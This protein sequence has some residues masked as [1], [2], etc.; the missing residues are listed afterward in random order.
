[1]LKLF[2]ILASGLAGG[3]LVGALTAAPPPEDAPA[4][5]ARQA[6]YFD[7]SLP[8]AERLQALERTVAAERDARQVLEEQILLLLEE[9]DRIGANRPATLPGDVPEGIGERERVAAQ[10]EAR[11]AS[12]IIQRAGDTRDEQLGS[13]MAAGF[14]PSQAAEIIDRSSELQWEAMRARFEAQNEGR[15]FNW[16]GLDT[17]PNWR[18]RQELGDADYERYLRAIGQPTTVVVQSVM[19]SSPASRIGL[20]PGDQVL[21]YNG[22][23]VFDP[24]ELRGLTGSG[25]VGGSVVVEIL[26]D[27]NRMQ[28]AVPSGPMGVTVNGVPGSTGN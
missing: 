17:N 22:T 25:A 20:Q 13:L 19:E 3:Y 24:G 5:Q 21:A 27:G 7:E 26:R 1:M 14:S 16:A 18:L 2:G 10:R 12:A 15:P 9:I 28:L 8:V 11:R 23:R 6:V 4:E